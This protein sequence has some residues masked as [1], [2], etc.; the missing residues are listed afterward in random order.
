MVWIG[1]NHLKDGYG[2]KWS[3]GAPLSLVNFTTAPLETN[4]Q[5]GVYNSAHG[6]QWQSLACESALPY[7]CKKTPNDTSIAEPLDSRE[8]T[9]VWI[10]LWKQGS[11]PGVEWSDGSPVTLTL[12]DQ[13]YPV[14]NLTDATLCVKAEK[15]VG[16]RM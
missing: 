9:N 3:D 5:C 15:T 14:N 1:L 11:S 6:G 8:V 2:W 10:G 13:Y 16:H 7:I 4:M 12:W